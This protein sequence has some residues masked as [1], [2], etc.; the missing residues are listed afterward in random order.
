MRCGAVGME[1]QGQG[2]GEKGKNVI[3]QVLFQPLQQQI[4][5]ATETHKETK[6]KKRKKKT[7]KSRLSRVFQIPMLQ[8]V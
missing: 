8:D 3:L 4:T 6:K 7:G 1:E 5:K 2:Q